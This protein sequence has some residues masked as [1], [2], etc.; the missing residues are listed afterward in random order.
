MLNFE[1]I[2]GSIYAIEP[3]YVYNECNHSKFE[4]AFRGITLQII[5]FY[6]VLVNVIAFIM[7]VVDKWFAK[8]NKWRVPESRLLL[9]CAIGGSVGAIFAMQLVRHK[10]QKL[11]FKWGVPAILLAQIAIIALASRLLANS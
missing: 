5:K 2:K 11:R 8:K 7:F 10:T 1:L 3:F 6:L 9:V 4:I